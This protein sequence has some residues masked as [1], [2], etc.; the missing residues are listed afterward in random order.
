MKWVKCIYCG[1]DTSSLLS[2]LVCRRLTVGKIY[3]VNEHFIEDFED[4]VK[5]TNN[6]GRE[7]LYSFYG[8]RDEH[9]NNRKWF[10]DADVEVRDNKIESILK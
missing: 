1:D 3:K 5:I 10:E 9:G 8:G 6:L 7:V 4:Y 2:R